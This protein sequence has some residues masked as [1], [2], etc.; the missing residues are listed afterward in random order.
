MAEE[1]KWDKELLEGARAGDFDRVKKAISKGA[2]A[3]RKDESNDNFSALH[4]AAQNSNTE[5]VKYLVEVAKISP[6]IIDDAAR[7]P[8]HISVR[9]GNFDLVKYFLE[10]HKINI[11]QKTALDENA[12]HKAALFGRFEILQYLI[13]SHGVLIDEPDMIENTPLVNA[14][15]KGYNDIIKLLIANGARVNGLPGKNFKPLHVAARWGHIETI[16]LLLSLGADPNL[17]N[18]DDQKASEIATSDIIIDLLKHA[19]KQK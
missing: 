18:Q 13:D 8:F 2:Y 12:A 19:E 6:H 11:N 10:K 7:L 15:A 4:Y 17:V 5:M 3:M 9:E 14:A 16:R 1:G